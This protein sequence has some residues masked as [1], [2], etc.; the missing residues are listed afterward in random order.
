MQQV[1]AGASNFFLP[2]GHYLHQ[3]AGS[4]DR[5]CIAVEVTFDV[6][7]GQDQFRRQADAAGLHVDQCQDFD[8]FLGVP[9]LSL[10]AAGHIGQPNFGVESV[11]EA[12]TFAGSSSQDLAQFR[13]GFCRDGG[14]GPG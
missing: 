11:G 4:R 3:P 10:E 6:D 1:V 5:Y 13:V 8:T 12:R 14:K 7:H 9:D 2:E